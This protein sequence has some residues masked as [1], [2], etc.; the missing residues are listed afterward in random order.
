M[1][2]YYSVWF[3]NLDLNLLLSHNHIPFLYLLCLVWISLPTT[4]PYLLEPYPLLL[5]SHPDPISLH[6][7]P[8]PSLSPRISRELLVRAWFSVP[9]RNL[10]WLDGSLCNNLASLSQFPSHPPSWLRLKVIIFR[11]HSFFFIISLFRE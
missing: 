1:Y 6:A 11:H 5:S 7:P 9:R 10:G 4:P 3:R 2:L 8:H